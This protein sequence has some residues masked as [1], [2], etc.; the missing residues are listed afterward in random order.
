MNKSI[1]EKDCGWITSLFFKCVLTGV[2]LVG[3]QLAAFGA[4]KPNEGIGAFGLT[5]VKTPN[6][7]RLVHR[8]VTFRQCYNM[9][10]WN[11][12]VCVASRAMLNSGCF[13]NRAQ[14]GVNTYPRWSELMRVAGYTTY[15]TGKWHVPGQPRFDVVKDVRPGMPNQTKEGYNRPKDAEDYKNGWKPWETKYDGFWKGGTHWT[16]VVADNTLEFFEQ[17]EKDD[18]PFFMYLAF[19]APHDP[20]Q[21]PKEYVDMY[22]LDSI[23]MPVNFLPE[24]PYADAICGKGLRDEKLM[25][26]PRT[27]YAVKV[28]RQEYYA[29]ITYMDYHIGRM[30]DALE[31]SGKAD[32]TVIIFTADHGLAVGHHGLVGKQ[33]MYE[34][35]M[36]PPFI[37]VGPGIKGNRSIDAPIYL[38]DAMAT[39]LDLAGAEKPEHVEFNSVLPL[40]SGK[41]KVQYERIYGKYINNQRMI[42]KDDWK[43]IFYPFAEKKMRLFNL[44]KDPMEMNDLVDNPE[45][46]PLVKDLKKEFLELQR[47]MGD[48]LD[49]DNPRKPVK[50]LR[51]KSASAQRL[52]K[53]DA[54]ITTSHPAN[55]G[56]AAKHHVS[57]MIDGNPK[58]KYFS[59]NISF[60]VTFSVSLKKGEQLAKS[61]ALMS[62]NDMTERDPKSWAFYGFS[63]G[64]KWTLL[65]KRSDEKFFQRHQLR[66]FKIAKPQAFSQYKLEVTETQGGNKGLQIAEIRVSDK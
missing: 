17:A 9:G 66:N 28:N 3:M 48:D 35:S 46:A 62:G 15:M 21:A 23:K 2:A 8:G 39:A 20:R 37:I 47:E 26:Y 13:V 52:P 40:L 18:K 51:K 60:P 22:P 29:S 38:Q 43:L 19:N 32:N 53:L 12:A 54:V 1:S 41:K 7:D 50:K 57:T 14:E 58:T 30:L 64:E 34:H 61:Y 25:P 5:E 27:E 45:Y 24:Y 10:A 6:L 44:K 56:I 59:S 42:R 4:E 65:D 36:R 16:Q 49:L 33:N 63:D 55:G 31:A 11:G